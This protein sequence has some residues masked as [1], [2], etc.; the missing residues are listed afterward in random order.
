MLCVG[1]PRSSKRYFSPR[2]TCIVDETCSDI[3]LR[4]ISV[5]FTVRFF[6]FTTPP[7]RQPFRSSF[8]KQTGPF[9]LDRWFVFH[10]MAGLS[11]QYRPAHYFIC[12]TLFVNCLN[13]FFLLIFGGFFL[14]F[15]F[16]FKRFLLT[17]TKYYRESTIITFP[18]RTSS[19]FSPLQ[20]PAANPQDRLTHQFATRPINF[21]GQF[22]LNNLLIT[23]FVR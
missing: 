5:A 9:P 17:C 6:I 3:S 1:P 7:L 21:A 10:C 18:R 23:S 13:A 4:I 15:R 2:N 20:A 14:H 22:R 8:D 19:P 12:V 11:K 16:F